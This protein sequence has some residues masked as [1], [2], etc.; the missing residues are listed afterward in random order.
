MTSYIN[1]KIRLGGSVESKI[2]DLYFMRLPIKSAM[3]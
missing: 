2:A 3:R 1:S